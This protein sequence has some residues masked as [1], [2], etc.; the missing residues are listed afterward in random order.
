[1]VLV[2]FPFLPPVQRVA[3]ERT[4][5]TAEGVPYHSSFSTCL[6]DDKGS[7]AEGLLDAPAGVTGCVHDRRCIGVGRDAGRPPGGQAISC[8]PTLMEIPGAASKLGLLPVT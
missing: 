8:L 2:I 3:S 4:P 6:K 7:P 1:M 5:D